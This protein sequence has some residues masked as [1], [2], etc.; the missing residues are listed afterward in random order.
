V[1]K[2]HRFYSARQETERRRDSPQCPFETGKCSTAMFQ[3]NIQD[4]SLTC[5]HFNFAKKRHLKINKGKNKDK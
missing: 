3:I 1:V 4:P 5:Q 2:N